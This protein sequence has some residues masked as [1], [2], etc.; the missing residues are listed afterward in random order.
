MAFNKGAAIIPGKGTVLVAAPDTAP[1]SNWATIDPTSSA[2]MAASGGWDALGHTSRENNVA[3]SKDGGEATPVGS[4]WD[5]NLDTQRTGTNWNV[6]VNSIQIDS[7][8]LGLAFGGGVLDTTAGSYDVGDIV[9][10]D[11]ALFIII[12]GLTTRMGLYIPNTSVSIG[13]APEFPT[14]AF[15]E[16]QLSAAIKNSTSTGK[17]FRWYHPAL[18]NPATGAPTVSAVSPASAVANANITIT[19]TNFVDVTR[20]TVGGTNVQMF[21]VTSP[22]SILATMPAGTAGSAPV[23]VTTV[24]GASNAFAYTRG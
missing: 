23:Q 19:G 21:V 17:K 2:Q 5:E 3:L 7:T 9:A 24:V 12:Q 13:D 20:V 8:T 15:F 14:D 4:W 11:K 22:T 1:P 10:Q 16:I 18:K 6:T